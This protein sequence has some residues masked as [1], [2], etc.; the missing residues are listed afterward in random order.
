MFLETLACLLLL[1]GQAHA[2]WCYGKG[3]FLW[4]P[5]HSLFKQLTLLQPVIWSKLP[6]GMESK[7]VSASPASLW[8]SDFGMKDSSGPWQPWPW[9]SSNFKESPLP[10]LTRAF[11]MTRIRWNTCEVRDEVRRELCHSSRIPQPTTASL[12]PPLSTIFWSS[13][14]SS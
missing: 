2:H 13:I 3:L 14:T 5:A 4:T 10:S 9:S 12:M 11:L 8:S 6:F 7:P 1:I